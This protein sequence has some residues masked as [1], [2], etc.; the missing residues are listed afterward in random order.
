MQKLKVAAYLSGVPSVRNKEKAGEKLDFLKNFIL[1]VNANR[2]IGISHFGMK[3]IDSDVALIQGFVHH[4][5]ERVP[6]LNLRRQVISNSRNKKTIIIDSNLFLYHCGKN[7]NGY[8]RY[9]VNGIF[10][11]T[12]FYFDTDVDPNRWRQISRDLQLETKPW[13]RSGDHILICC[14]RNGGWSMKGLNVQSWVNHLI[15][16]LKLHTDRPII[17]RGHPG[18]KKAPEYLY[19]NKSYKLSQNNH[20]KQDLKN[21][22]ATIT[23]NSSPGVASAI[24]GIPVFVTD[25]NPKDSQAYDVANFNLEKIEKPVYPDREHWLEKI[26]MSHW[27]TEELKNGTAWNFMRRYFYE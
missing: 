2:D 1:G 5:S 6:H 9:S 13:R 23:Y 17:V 11:T 24:E 18:D 16:Q 3:L 20:I 14:Q 4:G 25:N 7:K 15:T 19:K 12:G 10:P 8:L 27:N 26:S 21:A 22:W